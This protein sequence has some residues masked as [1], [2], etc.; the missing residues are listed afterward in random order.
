MKSEIYIETN[1]CTHNSAKVINRSLKGCYGVIID[2]KGKIWFRLQ[3]KQ[4]NKT[5]FVT[6]SK[7]DLERLKILKTSN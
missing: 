5:L 3:L 4:I 7:I 6:I 1:L 2:Q